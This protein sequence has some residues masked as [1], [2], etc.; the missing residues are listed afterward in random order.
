MSTGA[1]GIVRVWVTDVW[2]AVELLREVMNTGAWR[3]P[4]FA[5]RHAVT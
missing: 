1:T 2:D 5:E 3:D 4:A